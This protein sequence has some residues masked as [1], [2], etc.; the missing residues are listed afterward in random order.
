MEK[1]DERPRS[2]AQMRKLQALRNLNRELRLE[3]AELDAT[4]AM[5]K[6]RSEIMSAELER[7]IAVVEKLRREKE[8]RKTYLLPR[9]GR[10]NDKK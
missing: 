10:E 2:R 7:K 8:F 9:N 4:L 1:S 5:L 6:W 3:A